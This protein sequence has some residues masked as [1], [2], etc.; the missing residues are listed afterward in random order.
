MEIKDSVDDGT[1]HVEIPTPDSWV[2]ERKGCEI[3]YKHSHGT[4][5]SL[6]S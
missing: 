2:C 3:D 6:T 1:T 5:P 4:F